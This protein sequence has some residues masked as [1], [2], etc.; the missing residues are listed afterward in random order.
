MS[1]STKFLRRS[2]ATYAEIAG[3]NASGHLGHKTPGMKVYYIDRLLLAEEKQEGA[4][5]PPLELADSP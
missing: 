4:T 5:A 1:G 2:G 3:K